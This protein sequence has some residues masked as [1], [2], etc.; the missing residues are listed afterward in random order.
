MGMNSLEFAA[1]A[2]I[3]F[4]AMLGS[5]FIGSAITAPR[6]CLTL[7][8]AMWGTVLTYFIGFGIVGAL[9]VAY[10]A[11]IWDAPVMGNPITWIATTH[12]ALFVV[13][14]ASRVIAETI[15]DADRKR[16]DGPKGDEDQP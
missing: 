3:A 8:S 1:A 9:A 7:L 2:V 14:L 15:L 13:V 5:V 6:N 16:R 12:T 10:S 11:A 4:F